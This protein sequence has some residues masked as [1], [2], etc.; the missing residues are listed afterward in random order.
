MHWNQLVR[1]FDF[2]K[3]NVFLCHTICKLI[4]LDYQYFENKS[5][6]F[7][8]KQTPIYVFGNMCGYLQMWMLLDSYVHELLC[9]GQLRNKC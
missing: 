5:M 9:W 4:N 2:H 6:D 7:I 8:W 1:G 3:D